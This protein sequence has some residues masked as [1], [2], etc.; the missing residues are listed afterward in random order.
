MLLLIAE[1]VT[2]KLQQVAV[3]KHS[4]MH[5]L[6]RPT[7]CAGRMQHH[8]CTVDGDRGVAGE[9]VGV[10]EKI[11]IGFLPAADTCLGL[12]KDELLPRERAGNYIEPS[13]LERAFHE[14]HANAGG[15]AKQS[16]PD[17]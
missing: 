8:P 15:Q 14:T 5:R 17:S 6:S 7:H 16:E 13:I 3:L 11:N 4:V 9:N 1:G 10:F 12:V 2:A